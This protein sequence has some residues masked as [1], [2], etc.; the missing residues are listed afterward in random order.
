M[1][2]TMEN[3]PHEKS[4]PQ[5]KKKYH[6]IKVDESTYILISRLSAALNLKKSGVVFAGVFL[7]ATL[8][9]NRTDLAT[10]VLTSLKTKYLRVLDKLERAEEGLER[11]L[12]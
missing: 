8:I 6:S 10:R 11:I 7:L 2:V 3:T 12:S 9:E 5:K 1:G 4:I